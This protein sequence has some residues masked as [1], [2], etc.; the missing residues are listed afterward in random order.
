[1]VRAA[2]VGTPMRSALR[3][4]EWE[5]GVRMSA[6]RRGELLALLL[7]QRGA[8]RGGR[9]V[10]GIGRPVVAASMPAGRPSGS[11]GR[12]NSGVSGE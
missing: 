3:L 12:G 9:T 1:V 5:M 7:G 8:E 4:K 11:V 2:A 10:K 6:V